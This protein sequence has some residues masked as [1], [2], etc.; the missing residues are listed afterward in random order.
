VEDSIQKSE[1]SLR[2]IGAYAPVGGHWR[3]AVG[4][5]R[6]EDSG[7]KSEISLRPIGTYAPVGGQ[8]S[9]HMKGQEREERKEKRGQKGAWSS[10]IC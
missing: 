6:T 3:F 1:G 7:Q 9:E 2:P 5:R 10:V 8:M 4:D